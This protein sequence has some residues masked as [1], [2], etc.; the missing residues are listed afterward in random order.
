MAKNDLKQ[1]NAQVAVS[2]SAI[3]EKASDKAYEEYKK[4]SLGKLNWL[5]INLESIK[6]HDIPLFNIPK[7][8]VT[9]IIVKSTNKNLEELIDLVD[10]LKQ[11]ELDKQ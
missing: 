2:T 6:K 4:T 7:N 1:H 9:T 11:M 5:K 8:P 3:E 10:S